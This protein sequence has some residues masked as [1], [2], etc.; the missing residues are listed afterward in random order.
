MDGGCFYK[1]RTT[2]NLSYDNVRFHFID[3]RQAN[4]G[5]NCKSPTYT[6]YQHIGAGAKTLYQGLFEMI[7]SRSWDSEDELR[8]ALTDYCTT[9]F[10]G[11]ENVLNCLSISV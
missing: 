9:Y 6:D 3:T 5:I 1:D 4:F 8:K 11:V 10:Q 2:C 7:D